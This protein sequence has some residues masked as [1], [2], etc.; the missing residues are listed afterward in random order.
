MVVISQLEGPDY[1]NL[2]SGGPGKTMLGV[3]GSKLTNLEALTALPH[4]PDR[5]GYPQSKFYLGVISRS[6]H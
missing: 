5:A 4:Q 3:H 1:V 6:A 2:L